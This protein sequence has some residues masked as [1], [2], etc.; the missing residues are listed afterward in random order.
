MLA[1]CVRALVP[2]P[3]AMAHANKDLKGHPQSGTQWVC[4]DAAHPDAQVPIQL[5]FSCPS[6]CPS[7][8]VP[9][10][11]MSSSSVKTLPEGTARP[12][13]MGRMEE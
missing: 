13:S 6:S 12:T 9:P 1:S 3:E 8:G 5:S 2:L 7:N 10:R 4:Y 11:W